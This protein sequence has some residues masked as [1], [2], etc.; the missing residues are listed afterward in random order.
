[1][2]S[3]GGLRIPDA[4]RKST[5]GMPTKRDTTVIVHGIGKAFWQ[6]LLV[7]LYMTF[8]KNQAKKRKPSFAVFTHDIGTFSSPAS[9]LTSV[10]SSIASSSTQSSSDTAPASAV[11]CM[12][13]TCV[14]LA[15]RESTEIAG[16]AVAR[17]GLAMLRRVAICKGV[18][19]SADAAGRKSKND[20]SHG[21]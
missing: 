9:H 16:A 8:R 15:C 7:M 21:D 17:C 11:S 2:L 20:S 19:A 1:M 4:Q 10:H 13:T 14:D 5:H 18:T 12:T 6:R 3:L